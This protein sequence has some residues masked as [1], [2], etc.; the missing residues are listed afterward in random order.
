VTFGQVFQAGAVQPGAQLYATVVGL[1][2]AALV[3][4][5][6]DAKSFNAHGSVATAV[7]SLEAPA[8]ALN[9][10]SLTV[11]LAVQTGTASAPAVTDYHIDAVA[12][13]KSAIPNGGP[14]RNPPAAILPSVTPI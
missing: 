4:V 12:A 2:G 1:A 5:Q 3:A 13:L 7:L 6:M 11:D 9:N 14:R 8:A 10:Y